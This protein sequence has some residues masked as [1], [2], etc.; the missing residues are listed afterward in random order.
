[1][2]FIVFN[3]D[4][5]KSNLSVTAVEADSNDEEK[6]MKQFQNINYK[7]YFYYKIYYSA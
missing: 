3:L 2:L 6:F 1:M 7:L 4:P 5:E